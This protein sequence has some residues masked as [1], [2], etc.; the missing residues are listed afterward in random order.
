MNVASDRGRF[1]RL[2]TYQAADLIRRRVNDSSADK[3]VR[4]WINAVEDRQA[5]SEQLQHNTATSHSTLL[6]QLYN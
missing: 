6:P 3:V 4:I 5:S 2:E 1:V